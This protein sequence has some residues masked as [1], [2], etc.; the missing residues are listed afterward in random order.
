MASIYTY[1]TADILTGTVIEEVPLRSVKWAKELNGPGSFEGTIDADHPKAVRNVVSPGA[2]FI[3]VL[4]NGVPVWGGIIWVVRN[5]GG[6]LE[7]QAQGIWSYFQRRLIKASV[8]FTNS[9]QFTIAQTLLNNAASAP[10]GDLGVVVPNTTSGVVRTRSYFGVERKQLGEAVEQLAAVENGFDFEV[11]T[12][13]S[14]ATFTND[15]VFYYPRQGRRLSAV[16]D[17]SVHVSLD[18]WEVDA[19]ATAN[20]ISGLGSGDGDAALVLDVADPS[21]LA[22]YPLLEDTASFKDVVEQSTLDAHSRAELTRRSAPTA[23]PELTLLPTAETTVG[24]FVVGDEVRL[25]GTRGWSELDGWY[26]IVGYNVE[27][28]DEGDEKIR[29]TIVDTEQVPQ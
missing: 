24:S 9:D 21:K 27:V 6:V 7:I 23:L 20:S 28:T 14:G 15:V 5:K 17:V 12:S 29:V 25:R 3:Y 10:G 8:T 11:T 22:E 19:S 18:S 1:I 26:R 13:L 2:R 16:W 4:R